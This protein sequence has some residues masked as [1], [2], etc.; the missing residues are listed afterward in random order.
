MSHIDDLVARNNEL[1][2]QLLEERARLET[3]VE[4]AELDRERT[5]ALD[6]I[7]LANELND[8]L[9]LRAK[10]QCETLTNQVG[11]ARN[12]AKH[13]ID[14]I[15]A[16]HGD[17]TFKEYPAL[18]GVAKLIL[19][20]LQPNLPQGSSS[21]TD[22]YMDLSTP[23]KCLQA[24]FDIVDTMPGHD[25]D[26]RG[27]ALALLANIRA[28]AKREVDT[29]LEEQKQEYETKLAVLYTE[30]EDSKK[31]YSKLLIS[32]INER[33]VLNERI[34]NLINGRRQHVT[35]AKAD[36]AE[37]EQLKV[38]LAALDTIPTEEEI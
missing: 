35:E 25:H 30:I 12:Y 33:R 3:M 36:R 28:A 22:D 21:T 24:W 17:T 13:L 10:N 6:A 4:A 26:T 5:K 20:T 14:Y 7:D 29:T 11:R 23:E 1:E 16:E 19:E 27:A 9:I 18:S 32:D 31:E 8:A 2:K 15:A 34:D 38:D 37:V